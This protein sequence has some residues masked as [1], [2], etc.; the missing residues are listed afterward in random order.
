MADIGEVQ[1]G[2]QHP[3]SILPHWH[4][5]VRPR[6]RWRDR[7]GARRFAYDLWGDTVN[8]ACRLE[9]L[10]RA[11]G[12]QVSEATYQ[13]LEQKYQFEEARSITIKGHGKETIHT[14]C[15]RH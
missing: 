5:H 14:L 2:L 8:L 9:S 4:Q 13:R 7:R 6:R 3:R 10:G 15:G 1:P 12:I 11:G